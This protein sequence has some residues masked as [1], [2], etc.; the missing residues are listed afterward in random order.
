MLDRRCAHRRCEHLDVKILQEAHDWGKMPLEVNMKNI[1]SKRTKNKQWPYDGSQ[2]FFSTAKSHD[3]FLIRTLILFSGVFFGILSAAFLMF[4]GD[5][6]LSMLP[7]LCISAYIVVVN[8]GEALNEFVLN[9]N[10]SSYAD[11]EQLL[12]IQRVTPEDLDAYVQTRTYIRFASF[13]VASF[14]MVCYLAATL[15]FETGSFETASMV[16]C[17]AYI[18][19]TLGGIFYVRWNTKIKRPRII[20][21]DDRFYVP[22]HSPRP[23]YITM[24]QWALGQVSYHPSGP[25]DY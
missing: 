19:S 23:G 15:A 14:V 8:L 13:G 17:L 4:F 1:P 25:I 6:S 7:I 16:F 20:Y 18:L 2:S 5:I 9:L 12:E 11:P 21:R 3:P 10:P 24:A 22:R